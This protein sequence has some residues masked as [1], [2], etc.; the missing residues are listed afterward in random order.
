MVAWCPC[1]CFTC[2][3]LCDRLGVDVGPAAVAEG[4]LDSC[5]MLSVFL[6][7]LPKA[8]LWMQSCSLDFL[9][10]CRGLCRP[11]IL[12]V[13]SGVRHG[14]SATWSTKMHSQSCRMNLAMVQIFLSAHFLSKVSRHTV[15]A[16]Q[17]LP[18]VKN[19]QMLPSFLSLTFSRLQCV[20][21]Q[22]WGVPMYSFL[23][24]PIPS[25]QNCRYAKWPMDANHQVG[26]WSL[27]YPNCYYLS[28]L[29][30]LK[31]SSKKGMQSDVKGW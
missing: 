1:F 14:R 23:S 17:A 3:Q 24:F 28:L 4:R 16:W 19:S 26:L 20:D 10:C 6:E 8:A 15:P 18:Q 7:E 12:L 13:Q 9:L 30:D 29:G 25:T 31:S 27:Q 21:S 11:S 5:R 2:C 22:A